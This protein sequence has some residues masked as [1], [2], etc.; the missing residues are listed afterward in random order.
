MYFIRT[1]LRYTLIL[2]KTCIFLLY[3]TYAAVDKDKGVS[4]PTHRLSKLK[5]SKVKKRPHPK[6]CPVDS[7]LFLLLGPAAARKWRKGV[8]FVN[9]YMHCFGLSTR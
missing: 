2:L 9:Y 6:C 5:V 4:W 7:I 3:T 1:E 8:I